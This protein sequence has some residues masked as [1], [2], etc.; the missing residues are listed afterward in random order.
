[1][2][3]RP[4]PSTKVS[5]RG[6]GFSLIEVL[7]SMC[8]VSA[9]ILALVALTQAASRHDKMSELRATATLLAGD[10]A[11]RLRA[12][13]AGARLGPQGYDLA[14]PAWPSPV[15]AP[16]AS[17]TAA[18]PCTPAGLA[19]ADMASWTKRLRLT[20]PG[21]SAWL[22]YHVATASARESVDV[23]VAWRDP[24]TLPAGTLTERAATECPPAWSG[25][26]SAVRCVYLLVGL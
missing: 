2:T 25:T 16:S 26:V 6:A 4:V 7:V 23:W 12:N 15:T 19:R 3:R 9:G 1:M 10:I 22:K 24:D 8:I 17:C 18:T 14:S 13:A 20:M 5:R 21:G 11:D